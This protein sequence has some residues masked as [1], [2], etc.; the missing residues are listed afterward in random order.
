MPITVNAF[1]ANLIKYRDQEP[2]NGNAE[3]MLQT[4]PDVAFEFHTAHQNIAMNEKTLEGEKFLV[5]VPGYKG[6]RLNS[7]LGVAM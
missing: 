5:F 2:G 4:E 7:R 3:V 1:I 6:K